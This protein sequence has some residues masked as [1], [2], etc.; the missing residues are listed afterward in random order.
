MAPTRTKFDSLLHLKKCLKFFRLSSLQKVSFVCLT[1]TSCRLWPLTTMENSKTRIL[2]KILWKNTLQ[3]FYQKSMWTKMVRYH[4][5]SFSFS[6]SSY[7]YPPQKSEK[8]L[9][10]TVERCPKRSFLVKSEDWENLALPAKNNKTG[11]KLTQG[12]SR[13]QKKIF[14]RLTAVYV[15]SY[16]VK[17]NLSSMKISYSWGKTLERIYGTTNSIVMNLMKRQG[18]FQLKHSSDHYQCAYMGEKLRNTF[19]G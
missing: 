6:C 15:M 1:Q 13:H 12:L 19:A 14:W 16:L 9:S 5:R 2:L 11:Y 4:S 18:G 3:E 7:K 10:S 17:R 8:A